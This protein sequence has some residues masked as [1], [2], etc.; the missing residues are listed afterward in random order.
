MA[1]DYI[2]MALRYDRWAPLSNEQMNDFSNVK[3][4]FR[5][6]RIIVT[7]HHIAPQ[8]FSSPR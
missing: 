5:W 2:P 7:A 4:D 3:N 6:R 8:L 1:V